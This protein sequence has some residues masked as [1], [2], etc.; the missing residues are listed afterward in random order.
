VLSGGGDPLWP[1][2]FAV[3]A[4]VATSR[5]YVR[6]HHASDVLGGALLGVALG[7]LANHLWAPY[8]IG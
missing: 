4:V 5:A 1:V 3:A 7:L 2:Y 6:I 8:P